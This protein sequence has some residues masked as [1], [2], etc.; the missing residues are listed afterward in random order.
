MELKNDF[1]FLKTEFRLGKYEN[2]TP[3]IFCV[4]LLPKESWLG[5]KG[6]QPLAQHP[7]EP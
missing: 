3:S 7:N 1:Q 5:G 2:C 4:Q 6:V